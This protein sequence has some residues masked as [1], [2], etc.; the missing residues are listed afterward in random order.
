M[1]YDLRTLL[2]M[3]MIL[4]GCYVL[5]LGYGQITGSDLIHPL[6]DT[7]MTLVVGFYTFA[8]LFS[9]N[10]AKYGVEGR[11]VSAWLGIILGPVVLNWLSMVTSGAVSAYATQ[12]KFVPFW[13]GLA[14]AVGVYLYGLFKKTHQRVSKTAR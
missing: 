10:D 8:T 14:A 9:W 12:Y 7:V 1:Y 2:F 4:F 6:V 11:H 3:V 5:S 13:A